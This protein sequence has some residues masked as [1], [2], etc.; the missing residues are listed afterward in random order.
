V[1]GA[2]ISSSVF[3]LGKNKLTAID[4]T[5]SSSNPKIFSISFSIH[6]VI[7]AVLIFDVSICWENEDG[8]FVDRRSLFLEASEAIDAVPFI[9]GISRL[10]LNGEYFKFYFLCIT[11]IE[12]LISFLTPRSLKLNMIT[13]AVV[14]YKTSLSYL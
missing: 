1:T 5:I 7:T 4:A 6:N 12:S 13:S 9:D 2:L 10:F 11:K 8:N 3:T 14:P